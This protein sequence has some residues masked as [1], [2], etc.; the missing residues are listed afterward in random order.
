LE[1]AE[2]KNM[3]WN[4]LIENEIEA[5]QEDKFSKDMIHQWKGDNK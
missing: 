2:K 5:V 4:D 1:E 3:Q